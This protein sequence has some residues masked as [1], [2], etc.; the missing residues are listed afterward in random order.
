MFF[1][2]IKVNTLGQWMAVAL[3]EHRIYGLYLATA[4]IMAFLAYWRIEKAHQDH[5]HGDG[6]EAVLST[7]TLPERPRSFLAFVFDRRVFF[8]PSAI[9]DLKYFFVNGFVYAG[10][11]SQF[12]FTTQGVAWLIHGMLETAG[13]PVTEPLI[14]NVV[15]L[16]LYTLLAAIAVDFAVFFTH[17]MQH[18]I[19]LLWHFHSV[20]HSAEVLTPLTLYRLH[21]VDLIVTGLTVSLLTG[22]AYGGLFYLTGEA[23]QEMTVFG[24]NIIF[25]L[26]YVFGYN[27]RHSHVWLAYPQWLSRILVSPAQH[28]IH[29][30]S[31]PK[32]FDK[33]MGL[34][35]AFWDGLFGSLY[36]PKTYEKLTFGLSRDNPNPFKSMSD[37]YLMPFAWARR[38]LRNDYADPLRRRAV[39]GGMAAVAVAVIA[40]GVW[41]DGR[42]P[43]FHLPTLMLADLT[44]TEAHQALENGYE[45]VIVPTG[46]VE[47]N[48]P[49]VT[50]G[51]HNVVIAE[52]ARQM[53][54]SLGK[55]LVAPV[56]AYVPEGD[57]DSREGH[58]AFTGTLSVPEPVFEDVLEAT[59]RSL[60]AHGFRNVLFVGDSG[61][62]QAAQARVAADLQA[63]WAG[64]GMRVAS[65]DDYYYA[66]RQTDFLSAKGYSL[67]D[68]GRH[69]GIR[70]TSELIYASSGRDVRFENRYIPEGFQPGIDGNPGLSSRAIGADM[71]RL[72]VEAGLAQIR[73]VMEA[74]VT[75]PAAG[76]IVLRNGQRIDTGKTAATD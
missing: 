6:D 1:E 67:D 2:E 57:I 18:K 15:S 48:G 10:I 23:P 51:K 24:L 34:I 72:K 41:L 61:S 32:H 65:I 20:H 73:A 12:L 36:I 75:I 9:Q 55:T 35:F 30:S 8:H 45:T 29:H 39:Q 60:R 46:G 11:A 70:D 66:N 53:A 69:A 16:V 21:P 68:I 27:L 17:R 4:I 52:T 49:Y 14:S 54:Q 22:V 33:N 26:F 7:D 37:I 5:H 59:A 3:P 47:Q 25:M 74:P 31:D 62:S 44:W 42:K 13:G 19:P 56:M 38:T 76:E 58:M 43:G 64:E 50:L 28:Q 71:V 63:Q 40:G